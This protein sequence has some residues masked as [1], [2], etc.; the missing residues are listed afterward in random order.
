MEN[1]YLKVDKK[2]VSEVYTS[3]EPMD[4]LKVLCDVYDS[5]I[6]VQSSGW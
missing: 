1:P 4:N 3:S 2:M 5:R 6:S